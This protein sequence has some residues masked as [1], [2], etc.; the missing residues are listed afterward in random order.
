MTLGVTAALA[1]CFFCSR[2]LGEL[3]GLIAAGS[4]LGWLADGIGCKGLGGNGGWLGGRSCRCRHYG[5][6]GG[7]LGDVCGRSDRL[8]GR[9]ANAELAASIRPAARVRSEVR[10]TVILWI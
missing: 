9:V 10:I 1:G 8:G 2:T 7:N 5:G 6:A 4:R 3:A